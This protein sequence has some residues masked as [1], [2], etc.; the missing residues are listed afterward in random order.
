MS[1]T[2][3]M[4]SLL[5]QTRLAVIEDGEVCELYVRRPDSEN[6]SGN[7]Y[8]GRVENVLPG[9]NAAFV[10]IGRDKNGFLSAARL[11]S[12][13]Q[14]DRTLAER[15]KKRRIESVAR[16]GRSILVQV[17]KSEGGAKGPQLSCNISLPGRLMVLLDGVPYAGVSRKIE[18]PGERERLR[19][20]GRELTEGKDLGVILRTAANGASESALVEEFTRLSERLDELHRAAEHAAAPRLIHD[21]NA[22][23]LKAVRDRLKDGVDVL[24]AEGEPLYRRLKALAE[25]HAP[26]YAERVRLHDGATPLFDLYSVDT[27]VDKALQKYVWLKDGGSLVIEETEALT[28]V[29]VNTGKNVGKRSAEETV[30]KTNC[31]AARELMRQLRLR[32]IAGIVIVDFIDMASED[33]KSAVL[34]E[35]RGCA[36]RDGNRTRVLG[37]TG[38]GLVELTRKRERL[39]LKRQLMH[40]CSDCGG[41]GVVPS[42]ET[43]ARR[44]VR[45]LWRRRRGGNE[46]PLLVE[47][48]P[49]VVSRLKA[50]GASKGGSTYAR[51]DESLKADEFRVSPVDAN[52]LPEGCATLKQRECL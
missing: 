46:G 12:E 31:L 14:G 45:E 1:Q 36:A 13:V 21:D 25:E 39:P 4:E 15:A 50:I 9:M 7:I 44:A 17:L 22:L 49:Q 11:P 42:H 37:F 18:D 28:V 27:A 52:A 3:L 20:L 48:A 51:P 5:G 30:F 24:W 43:T 47:A 10:D 23:E 35:L 26:D 29:D 33:H 38:L 34:E 40:T 8:L 6:L 19:Q 41:N 2:L 32:D 16:P